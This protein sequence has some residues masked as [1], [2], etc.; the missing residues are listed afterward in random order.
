[1][2]APK[3]VS[4]APKIGVVVEIGPRAEALVDAAL[5]RRLIELEVGDIEVPSAPGTRPE[6]RTA[7]FYRIVARPDNVLVLELWERGQLH[8]KRTIS[9]V[10]G[11]ERLRARLVALAAAELA[12]HLRHRRLVQARRHEADERRRRDQERAALLAPPFARLSYASGASLLAL[13]TGDLLVAGPALSGTLS[14]GAGPRLALRAS[15]LHG[16]FEGGGER[17]LGQWYDLALLPSYVLSLSPDY[18]LDMGLVASASLVHAGQGLSL[19]GI[20]D[21]SESWS[22]RLGAFVALESR[23]TRSL[24]WFLGPSAG[25]VMRRVPIAAQSGERGSLA[26]LWLGLSLGLTV[27]PMAPPRPAD[28]DASYR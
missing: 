11:S 16:A 21:Q 15:S 6:I 27:D 3:P 14:F 22:A 20:A 12:R 7:L 13:T 5:T 26:G 24:G 8:G 19:D 23:W 9:G 18:A 25:A 28:L 17:A 2:V 1:V 10:G 4:A